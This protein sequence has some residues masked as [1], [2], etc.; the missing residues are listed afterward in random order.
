M[1]KKTISYYYHLALQTGTKFPFT[2]C[3]HEVDD[4]TELDSPWTVKFLSMPWPGEHNNT[5][6]L[7]L[8]TLSKRL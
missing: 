1:S 6:E 8:V 3:L 2:L 4:D 5:K 7:P